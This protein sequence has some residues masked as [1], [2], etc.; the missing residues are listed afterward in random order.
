MNLER[1]LSQNTEIWETF[2]IIFIILFEIVQIILIGPQHRILQYFNK[3]K[4]LMWSLMHN[5]LC[6]SHLLCYIT[7]KDSNYHWLCW[8]CSILYFYYLKWLV[9]NGA[10]DTHRK[11]Q[12]LPRLNCCTGIRC[13]GVSCNM[14]TDCSCT[15]LQRDWLLNNDNYSY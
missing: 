13:S 9:P 4:S 12:L 8:F 2:K 3:K 1:V 5:R 10:F 14:W 7:L 15:F 6:Y 11:Q